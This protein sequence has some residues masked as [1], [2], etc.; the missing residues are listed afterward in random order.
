MDGLSSQSSDV[1][2]VDGKHCISVSEQNLV[3]D[4]LQRSMQARHLTISIPGTGCSG[5][6]TVLKL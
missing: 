2:C 1:L 5:C 6:R 4:M 3:S